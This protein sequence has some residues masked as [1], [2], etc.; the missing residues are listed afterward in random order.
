MFERA[1]NSC[2]YYTLHGVNDAN[3]VASTVY[4]TTSVIKYIQNIPSCSLSKGNLALFLS[5]IVESKK[6]FIYRVENRKWI[7]ARKGTPGN[8]TE[9]EDLMGTIEN[10]PVVMAIRYAR[11]VDTLVINYSITLMN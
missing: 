10:L 6:I 1:G 4:K 8:L 11:K 3:L 5:H 9:I 7:L 2:D